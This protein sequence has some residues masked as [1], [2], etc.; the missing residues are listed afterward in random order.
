MSIE[1]FLKKYHSIKSSIFNDGVDVIDLEMINPDLPPPPQC[2]DAL[3]R[4]TFRREL[5]KYSVAKGL[6]K[7]RKAFSNR[8][9]K[10]FSVDFDFESEICVTAGCKDGVVQALKVL[11]EKLGSNSTV[12][13]PKPTYPAHISAAKFLGMNID[14]FDVH[15]PLESFTQTHQKI[16]GPCIAL[17]NFPHNPTGINISQVEFEKFVIYA[18]QN[19][20]GLINDFAYGEMVYSGAGVASS[21]LG[22]MHRKN[23]LEVATLSKSHSVPGWRIGAVIGDSDLI[24]RISEIKSITDYGI[25][26]PV[27]LAAADALLSTERMSDDITNAYSRRANTLVRKLQ[28]LGWEVNMPDSGAAV[29]AKLPVS[30]VEEFLLTTLEKSGVAIS[31]GALYGQE[32]KNFVRFALVAGEARLAEAVERISRHV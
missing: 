29:W 32:Y 30:D 19:N 24:A 16:V 27:Q 17:L 6:K 1:D 5:H 13:L 10:I 8:Y 3:A 11:Q 7:L 22:F 20:I 25:F 9:S 26:L 12:I 15:K 4:Y 2:V 28:A 23:I 14:F 21:V 31:Y 18:S